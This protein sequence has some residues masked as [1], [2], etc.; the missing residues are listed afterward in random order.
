MPFTVS[1]TWKQLNNA[2]YFPVTDKCPAHM[3]MHW[4]PVRGS[5]AGPAQVGTQVGTPEGESEGVE[6]DTCGPRDCAARVYSTQSTF[7]PG[8]EKGERQKEKMDMLF[9]FLT[10]L[11]SRR[12]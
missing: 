11:I 3:Q 8:G 5:C 12:D 1:G 2:G 4:V 6:E 9:I 7:I 10:W